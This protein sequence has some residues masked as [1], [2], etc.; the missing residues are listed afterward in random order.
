[1][2]VPEFFAKLLSFLD[3]Q[4]QKFLHDCSSATSFGPIN[5]S[6]LNTILQDIEDGA[7]KVH[8]PMAAKSH[9]PRHT[10]TIIPINL[11]EMQHY[12]AF[13]TTPRSLIDPKVSFLVKNIEIPP[14]SILMGLTTELDLI[15]PLDAYVGIDGILPS[16]ITSL[17]G[18]IF[19]PLSSLM[20]LQVAT[21][22]RYQIS[23][24]K[25]LNP[26]TV[27]STCM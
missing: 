10:P 7:F 13:L 8:V 21:A 19:L 20:T 26:S 24:S 27:G 1:M 11:N 6:Y 18:V 16:T 14:V 25:L 5:F 17:S 4:I 12:M 22:L 23:I 3:S 2:V 9:L 15:Q